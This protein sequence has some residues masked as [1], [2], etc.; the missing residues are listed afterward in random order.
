MVKVSLKDGSVLEVEKGTSILEVA[1][2][3][4]EGLARVATCGEVNGEVK[5]LRYALEGDCSLVIH[6]FKPEDLEGKKAYWRGASAARARGASEK[7][8]PG[9]VIPGCMKSL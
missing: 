6:T 1:R 2:K 5:D 9:K 4:S 3:I 8:Q 7:K